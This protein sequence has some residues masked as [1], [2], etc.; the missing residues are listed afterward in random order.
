MNEIR[1]KIEQYIL[2]ACIIEGTAIESVQFLSEKNFS[3]Y[4]YDHRLIFQAIKSMNGKQPIDIATVSFYMIKTHGKE[5]LNYILELTSLVGSTHNI[6]HHSA[7]LLQIDMSEKLL[8]MF[9]HLVIDSRL[10][11]LDVAILNDVMNDLKVNDVAIW[12]SVPAILVLFKQKKVS[13][14]LIDELTSF[15][16]VI[17]KKITQV[18]E[19]TQRN[20]ILHAVYR[21]CKT[22]IQKYYFNQLKESL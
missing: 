3:V 6:Q 12:E 17:N 8:N 10:N 21:L 16:Q 2:G 7:I 20:E 11:T 13:Q 1:K 9:N 4:D 18:R 14:I 5:Y 22:D 15:N 19:N